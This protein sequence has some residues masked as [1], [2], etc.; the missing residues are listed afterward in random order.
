[1]VRG[2]GRIND[3]E[4]KATEKDIIHG[5]GYRNMIIYWYK[6]N[7]DRYHNIQSFNGVPFSFFY[8]GLTCLGKNRKQKS[9]SKGH[10]R[11][12]DITETVGE[13]AVADN[14]APATVDNELPQ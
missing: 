3:L 5:K 7:D 12:V 6:I 1:M 14:Q 4:F 10:C 9:L 11:R 2:K 8:P 13:G